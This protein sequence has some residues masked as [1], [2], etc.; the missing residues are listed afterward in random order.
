MDQLE[1][2]ITIANANTPAA[3]HGSAQHL[4]NLARTAA[5]R[6]DMPY[7][8]VSLKAISANTVESIFKDASKTPVWAFFTDLPFATTKTTKRV[9][10]L[11]METP[12]EGSFMCIVLDPTQHGD[13]TIPMPFYKRMMHFEVDEDGISVQ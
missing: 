10:D 2:L 12:Q 11:L 8:E 7:L 5:Q 6:V 1:V 3:M 13:P 4:S 9:L